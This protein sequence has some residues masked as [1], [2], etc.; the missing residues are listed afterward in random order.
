MNKNISVLMSIYNDEKNVRNAIE[1]ILNQTYEKFELLLLDDFST[2]NT[3]EICNEYLKKDK[4][5]K[6]Y[7]NKKNIGLTKSLN[8]LAANSTGLYIARQDSDDV[9]Y[10]NRLHEQFNF[11]NDTNYDGCTTLAKIKNKDKVI[12]NISKYIKPSLT[13]KFKNPFIHGTLM[14]KRDVFKS[15][16]FYDENFYYSQDF[17]LMK[18]LIENKYEVKIIKKVLYELN[19]ENNISSSH[20]EEQKYYADCVRKDK[21]PIN[22]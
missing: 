13:I 12:P 18:N 16:G 22:I 6:L 20:K 9:S 17:K 3:Y 21:T 10:L 1:S 14:L 2:D 15:V 11:L 19:M 8:K 7:R 4:R 5:I